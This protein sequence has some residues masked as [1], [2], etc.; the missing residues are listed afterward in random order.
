MNKWQAIDAFW[1][2]F[3]WPAYDKATVPDNAVMPYITYTASVA[4]FESPV[5]LDASLWIKSTSWAEI[6]QKSDEIAKRLSPH[7]IQKLDDGEYVFMTQ[8]TPFSQRMED[9]DDTVKR[10]YLNVMAEYFTAY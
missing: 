8:G 9:E 6:S 5:L 1:N 2:S 7:L 3:E 4:S 10:L